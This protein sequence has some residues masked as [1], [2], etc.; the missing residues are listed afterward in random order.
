MEHIKTQVIQLQVLV[1]Q[2]ELQVLPGVDYFLS[3][4][5]V[6]LQRIHHQMVY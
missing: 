4:A 6:Q 2:L 5:M 3:M 1:T